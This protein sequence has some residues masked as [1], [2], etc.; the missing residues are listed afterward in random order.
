MGRI[1][2]ESARMG[3]LVENLLTLARLDQVPEA[4]RK[5]V[6]LAELA[7]DTADDAR[8]IAPDRDIELFAD[9]AVTVLGDQ[10]QLRQV[11]GNLVR[12]AL[13]HTPGGTPIELSV[14]RGEARD[15]LLEVRDHGHGLPTDDT[16]ALFER[17]WRADPGRERGRGGAGLGLS[18][19]AAIVD[20]HGGRVSAANAPGGGASFTIS[21]PAAGTDTAPAPPAPA[22]APA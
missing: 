14:R 9:E 6:D 1:E 17:F 13:M 7:R 18:I 12:N 16:D 20:A 3:A 11:L 5:P 19:V 10:S 2:D 15:A 21:L 4:A 8:A 22:A